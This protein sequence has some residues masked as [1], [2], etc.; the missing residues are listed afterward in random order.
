M[1]RSISFSAKAWWFWILGGDLILGPSLKNSGRFYFRPLFIT[2]CFWLGGSSLRQDFAA[3]HVGKK[4]KVLGGQKFSLSAFL[5]RQSTDFSLRTGAPAS[6]SPCEAMHVEIQV[7][8]DGRLNHTGALWPAV[9]KRRFLPEMTKWFGRHMTN[10]WTTLRS[11]ALHSPF[12]TWLFCPAAQTEGR[13]T[14][15]WD[16]AVKPKFSVSRG[17]WDSSCSWFASQSSWRY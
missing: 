2:E 4:T 7:V 11:Q 1:S 17:C 8:G 10:T 9:C 15:C 13:A 6:H 14:T 16:Q 12:W 5:R 3:A